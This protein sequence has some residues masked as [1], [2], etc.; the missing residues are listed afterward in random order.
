MTGQ[1]NQ[2]A[3]T[4]EARGMRNEE[5]RIQIAVAP[6]NFFIPISSFLIPHWFALLACLFVSTGCNNGNKP[7]VSAAPPETVTTKSGI[8]MVAIPAGFFEMGSKNGRADEKPVHK[9]WVDS[10]LMDKTEM[11]QAVWEKIGKVEAMSN[12][13][14]VNGPDFP[15]NNVSWRAA[16]MFCNA[17]SR[18]EGLKAC[19]NE[20]DA[21]CDFDAD[22]YRLPTE[23]EWEYACRAGT[24]TDYSF[25]SDGRRLGD[26]GW[27]VDNSG[28]KT[29]PVS[30][31]KANPWGLFDMHG[32][33]A[34]WCNDV[35]DKDYYQKKEEKNPR[36][37]SEGQQR[38]LR[39][40]S[41]KAPA[42]A[43]RSAYRLGDNPGIADACLAP[44]ANGF[45][46]VRTAPL[47][48]K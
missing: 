8:E 6:R 9:V 4:N 1:E 47:D 33:V 20:D 7:A 16:A 27:F 37:P 34:E 44:D 2:I 36:G 17:R 19:Y 21:T 41:W 35:F 5:L 46:C 3:M 24:T 10:F 48:Q 31:K 38:V 43:A 11:T 22:G 18:F 28:K 32:N 40:G 45:R 12:P 23:A 14:T 42:E 30:Q 25:G 13:S 29:H 39:G 26:H 15:V